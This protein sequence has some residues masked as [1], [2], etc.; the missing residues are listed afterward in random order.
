MKTTIR[1]GLH[2]PAPI[3]QSR[4]ARLP[5]ADALLLL[6]VGI[7]FAD[8][9][10]VVLAVPEIIDGFDVAVGSASWVITAYN[11]AVAAVAAG[12]LVVA[13]RLAPRA[14]AAV[15]LALFAAASA[16]C[17]AAPSLATLVASRAVQG[18]AAAVLLVAAVPLLAG[19]TGTRAW[20]LAATVG[21][22]SG[23][24]LGGLLTEVFSWRAIFVVQAPVAAC[25]LWAPLRLGPP[26]AE[27]GGGDAG[28]RT[29]WIADAS[30][31]ALSAALV[32]ALFLVVVLLID[33]FGWR[34]LP[35][36]LL[37]TVLPA[38]AL[39]GERLGRYVAPR[40]AASGGGLLIAAGLVLLAYLSGPDGGLIVL[41][42][43]L[44]GA[45]LGLAAGPLGH[46]AFA[47]GA[48]PRAAA[49]TV[50]G[51]H[52]GLVV[53]LLLVTPLLVDS[54]DRL[55]PEAE[56]STGELVLRAPIPLATKVP[57]VLDLARAAAGGI[58]VGEVEKTL[59]AHA[60]SEHDAVSRLE[61]RV[62]DD[63]HG[64]FARAFRSS[65]LAC[66]AL[67]LVAAAIALG[68]SDARRAHAVPT[69]AAVGVL[70]VV[71][72]AAAAVTADARRDAR[73]ERVVSADPCRAPSFRG[74]GLDAVTQRIALNALGRAA[75]DLG[76]TRP[77]L[78][79]ALLAGRKSVGRREIEPA[80]RGGVIDA[81]DREE[82]RGTLGG[83]EA[84]LL[85]LVARVT[86]INRI[87]EALAR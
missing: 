2:R 38:V 60:T 49:R 45:G 4:P 76:T 59:R 8:S 25:A 53:G 20:A 44:C 12:L 40:V 55:G 50:F 68:I 32:G 71:L 27:D 35:A 43:A 47:G 86:P 73:S 52:L 84:D 13:G 72:A 39:G 77:A 15:G 67:G 18:A 85:R 64:R 21:V 54:L 23:P 80:L 1:R 6:A 34:P 36:A 69:A 31:A 74:R 65:F 7:A 51:R 46:L 61:E 87:I 48:T 22:A 29:R 75:C 66:A 19:R 78:L 62:T 42:L 3:A 17:A 26:A 81:I 58:S 70:V 11:V 56:T 82:R 79:R 16:G 30:L 41:G 14:L 57:L 83:T 9:S 63:L 5:L 28:G 24:A 33:G 37:A 10:I